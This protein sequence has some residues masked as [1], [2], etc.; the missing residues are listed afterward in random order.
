MVFTQSE[1]QSTCT[2]VPFSLTSLLDIN[3]DPLIFPI[4][5]ILKIILLAEDTIF[6]HCLYK[7]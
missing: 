1:S 2:S 3:I 7:N 4:V 6:E 5:S